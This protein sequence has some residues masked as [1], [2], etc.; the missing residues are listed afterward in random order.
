MNQRVEV[1]PGTYP[2]RNVTTGVVANVV[3]PTLT[4]A[5]T[6]AAPTVGQTLSLTT[7]AATGAGYQW[8]RG[9]TDI[10]GATAATYAAVAADE[11]QSLSCRVTSGVQSVTST[12]VTV[13]AAAALSAT[14]RGFSALAFGAAPRTHAAPVT[15]VAGTRYLIA[16]ALYEEGGGG[17]TDMVLT[18]NGTAAT[19]RGQNAVIDDGVICALFDVT[20][21]ASGTA[22]VLTRPTGAFSGSTHLHYFDVTSGATFGSVILSSATSGDQRI[23]SPTVTTGNLV[24]TIA[25]VAAGTGATWAGATAPPSSTATTPSLVSSVALALNV[26]AASP[27]SVTVD[28]VGTT[29]NN[30]GFAALAGVYA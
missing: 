9:A 28:R 23:V 17:P 1:G 29:N 25:A 13:G 18:V 10:A 7:N 26:P 22:A 3:V 6:P 24:V 12:G 20:P 15:L 27:R 8:R 30:N 4:V 14:Y 5:V 21:A 19:R 16:A 2:V 11:A